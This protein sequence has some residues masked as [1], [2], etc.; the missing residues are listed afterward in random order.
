MPAAADDYSIYLRQAARSHE[1]FQDHMKLTRE[2]ELLRQQVLRSQLELFNRQLASG[3]SGGSDHMLSSMA[4]PSDDN[5][6]FF[7]AMDFLNK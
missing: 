2:T 1:L 5:F 6:S 7:Q 3:R 4:G